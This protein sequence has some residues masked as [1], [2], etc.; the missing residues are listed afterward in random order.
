[1]KTVQAEAALVINAPADALY[2]VIADYHVG[3]N[4]I[5]PKPPFSDL[6]VE[7]GGVG[8]GTIISFTT[9]MMGTTTHFHQVVSEPEQGRVLMETDIE[10]GQWSRFTLEP[11]GDGAQT[12]VTI[13]TEFPLSKGIKGFLEKLTIPPISRRMFNQELQNLAAYVTRMPAAV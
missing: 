9:H 2:A 1:M 4:A 7:Q 12:R 10:T 6:I 5:V 11:L 13:T 3:H 8:A